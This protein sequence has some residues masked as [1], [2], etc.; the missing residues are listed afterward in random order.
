M[1]SAVDNGPKIYEPIY[2]EYYIFMTDQHTDRGKVNHLPAVDVNDK[3]S[4][5]E[6]RIMYIFIL[7]SLQEVILQVGN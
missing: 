5:G 6:I 4:P 3:H 7:F 1:S 2:S